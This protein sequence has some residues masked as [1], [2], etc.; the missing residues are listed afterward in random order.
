MFTQISC[1]EGLVIIFQDFFTVGR[2]LLWELYGTFKFVLR[3][4]FFIPTVEK[5]MTASGGSC[6]TKRHA[7]ITITVQDRKPQYGT[8]QRMS[9]LYRWQSYR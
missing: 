2:S 8:N 5:Q 3:F 7:D 4:F 9:R 1:H 6:T